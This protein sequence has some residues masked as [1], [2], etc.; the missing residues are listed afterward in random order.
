RILAAASRTD[1]VFMVTENS[2]Y[3]PDVIVARDVIA[4]G[5]IGD[6]LTARAWHNSPPPAVFYPGDKPW[7]F[8]QHAMGGGIAL[9]TGS[10]W[11]RPLR[12]VLGEIDEVVATTSR[13]WEAMDGESLV[14]SL[15]RFRSGVVASFDVMLATGPVARQPHFQFTGTAGELLV[16]ADGEARLFDGEVRLF[17]GRDPAGTVVGGGGFMASYEGV[18]L[19]FEAAVLDGTPLA[20]SAEYSLGEVRAAHAIVRSAASRSWEPVW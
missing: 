2:Q 15:C 1:R 18:W 4:G 20:A 13:T 7:R 10:H 12:M 11:M 17:N 14:R 16:T 5:A 6:I 8:D 9:D 19:D 3:W